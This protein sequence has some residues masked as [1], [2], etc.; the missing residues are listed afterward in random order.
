M[1]HSLRT[2]S[3]L[4]LSLLVIGGV[5]SAATLAK[6][7]SKYRGFQLGS[8]LAAVAAQAG[9]SPSA[10][11]VIHRRPALIQELNWRPETFGVSQTESVQE[12]VF[13]FYDGV[14]FQIAVTYD[15]SETEGMTAGDFIE[16]ISATYGTAE[17][18]TVPA[19]VAQDQ[20]GSPEEMVARWQDSQYSFDLIRSSYG[21]S[22]KMI[23]VLTRLEAP[24]QAAIAEAKRLDD[25]EAPQRAAAQE[26]DQKQA[27]ASKLEAARLLNKPK[28]RQ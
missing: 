22:F 21:P 26:A 17:K 2:V 28:F 10:A 8:S 15:R 7:L 19:S 14:L 4:A 12:V 20:F 23:G 11:K 25:Q 24:A 1:I 6:D 16:A 27:E 3:K 5:L 9:V 13:S 18:P